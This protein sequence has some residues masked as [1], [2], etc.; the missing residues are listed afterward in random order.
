MN[1]VEEN[2]AHSSQTVPYTYYSNCIPGGTAGVIA[3]W[4]KEFEINYVLKGHMQFLCGEQRIY[5]AQGDIV[6]VCP[7][8]LHGV[9]PDGDEDYEYDTLVFSGRLVGS[10]VNDRCAAEYIHPL[11][12][13]TKALRPHITS[14][15]AHYEQIRNA[16]KSIFACAKDGTA[17]NDMLLKSAM[18][19]LFWLLEQD[20]AYCKAD[21]N[22]TG[23]TIPHI[24]MRSFLNTKSVSPPAET[25][26]PSTGAS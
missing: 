25:I 8:A 17:Q 4:H 18:F 16:V 12:N 9:F 10:A 21:S 2:I 14:T 13:G 6:I 24:N 20:G 7:N 5:A 3:H 1:A 19:R 15:S 23:S 11:M 22:E 26:P